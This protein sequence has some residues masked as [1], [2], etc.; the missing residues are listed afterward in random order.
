MRW[1]HDRKLRYLPLNQLICS[2]SIAILFLHHNLYSASIM[3][4][5]SLFFVLIDEYAYKCHC[6]IKPKCN[7]YDHVTSKHKK[8]IF[9]FFAYSSIFISPVTCGPSRYKHVQFTPYCLEITWLG[10]FRAFGVVWNY[11]QVSEINRSDF[12]NVK[13]STVF[14]SDIHKIVSC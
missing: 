3:F 9:A 12:I 13:D 1:L 6:K 8:S 7:W 14:H 2:L 10:W 5:D 4:G 11:P